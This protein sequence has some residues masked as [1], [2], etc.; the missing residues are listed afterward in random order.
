MYENLE[1]QRLEQQ[2][3]ARELQYRA[4]VQSRAL[5]L[6]HKRLE[7]AAQEAEA[8]HAYREDVQNDAKIS[9]A[10]GRI[11][12]TIELQRDINASKSGLSRSQYDAILDARR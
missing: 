6:H 9:R 3:Q 5:T 7:I 8:N 12:K 4:D 1:L 11:E 10:V 2:R